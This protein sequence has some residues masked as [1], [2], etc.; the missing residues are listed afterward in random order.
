MCY[1]FKVKNILNFK[2]RTFY[3][4]P[5][6]TKDWLADSSKNIQVRLKTESTF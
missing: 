5:E 1:P 2:S 6:M 3:R 4:S